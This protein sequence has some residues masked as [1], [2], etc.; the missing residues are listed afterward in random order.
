M[1]NRYALFGIQHEMTTNPKNIQLLLLPGLGGD[2]RMT[3]HQMALPYSVIAPDFIAM[4]R[5]ETLTAYAKRY[6]E[7][8]VSS[9]ILDAD[10]PI[11]LAGYSFGSAIAQ[12]LTRDIPTLGVII[13]GGLFHYSEIKPFIRFFGHYISGLLPRFIYRAAEPFVPVVMRVVSGIPRNDIELARVMYHDLPTDFFRH[14]YQALAR[15]IG[16][17]IDAPMLRIHGEHDQIILCP[18]TTENVV[19]IPNTKH[20]I[21]HAQPRRVNEEIIK[22]VERVMQEGTSEAPK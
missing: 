10:R 12:E 19:V 21:G 15:W 22:F 5:G 3:H 18:R 7:Y 16:C 11:F 13:I 9:K 4:H 2:H 8:L 6:G 1:S 14:G 20:L 17:T